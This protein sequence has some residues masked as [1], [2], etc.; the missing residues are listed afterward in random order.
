M[1]R[2]K[3]DKKAILLKISNLVNRRGIWPVRKPCRTK[4]SR[5]W[6]AMRLSMRSSECSAR[7]GSTCFASSTRS[8]VLPL[9]NIMRLQGKILSVL[10]QEMVRHTT[11]CANSS[12]AARTWNR[13]AIFPET[14][15]CYIY[16][17]RKQTKLLKIS[18]KF[19]ERKWQQKYGDET[20][21]HIIY[22]KNSVVMHYTRKTLRDQNSRIR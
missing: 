17:L 22:N 5:K 9:I 11:W 18:E 2:D 8:F 14:G 20:N 4:V 10:W 12:S 13:C 7:N 1:T 6:E 21:K 15:N 16:F 19:W 3:L